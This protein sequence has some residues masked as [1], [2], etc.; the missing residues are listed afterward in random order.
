MTVTVKE[1]PTLVAPAGSHWLALEQTGR[2]EQEPFANEELYPILELTA[3]RVGLV[4]ATFSVSRYVA[5]NWN[6]ATQTS[7]PVWTD[8]NIYLRD[9][10]TPDP[11]MPDAYHLGRDAAGVGEATRQAIRE[12]CE[13]II[14]GWLGTEAYRASRRKTAAYAVRRELDA[15]RSYNLQN[16]ERTLQRLRGEL[17]PMEA[18]HLASMLALLEQAAEGLDREP[19]AS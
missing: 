9:V 2:A 4:R 10:R 5:S 3:P 16:T 8:W 14:R 1:T 17:G 18:D 15:P 13:P 6:E 7:S 11:D 19:L 12:A